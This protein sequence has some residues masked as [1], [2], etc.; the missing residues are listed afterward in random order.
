MLVSNPE[1][2]LCTNHHKE[3]RRWPMP[4]Y[5]YTIF[6]AVDWP[7]DT[8]TVIRVIDSRRV[9]NLRRLRIAE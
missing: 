7:G 9:R 4:E 2:G 5:P 6:Y 1:F 8:L 3:L